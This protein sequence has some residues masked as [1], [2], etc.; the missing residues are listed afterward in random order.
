[1]ID[2]CKLNGQ[3]GDEA[4]VRQAGGDENL[5]NIFASGLAFPYYPTD[6]NP[7]AICSDEVG[8]CDGGVASWPFDSTHPMYGRKVWPSGLAKL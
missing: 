5:F 7:M 6:L 4:M 1:M 2:S 8:L 3:T